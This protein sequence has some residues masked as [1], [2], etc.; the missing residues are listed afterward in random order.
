[1]GNKKNTLKRKN[2]GGERLA[3]WRILKQYNLVPE[4]VKNNKKKLKPKIV[5]FMFSEVHKNTIFKK[6]YISLRLV[7]WLS[8]IH[9]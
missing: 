3:E 6:R 1:M 2:R 4:R 8:L 7:Y 9:I 5:V